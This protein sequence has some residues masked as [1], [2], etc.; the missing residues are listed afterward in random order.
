METRV[1]RKGEMDWQHL[2]LD[3]TETTHLKRWAQSAFV[4]DHIEFSLAVLE[5]KRHM[6]EVQDLAQYV[7]TG[8]SGPN[9][10]LTVRSIYAK[11]INPRGE[12]CVGCNSQVS[13]SLH[14]NYFVSSFSFC[15]CEV[16]LTST[17]DFYVIL[18]FLMP[19]FRRSL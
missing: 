6:L 2:L 5:Y 19:T 18:L 11:Y 13:S 15:Y 4:D 7:L 16:I 1:N 14:K 9:Q 12:N 8:S 10:R 17:I 3:P